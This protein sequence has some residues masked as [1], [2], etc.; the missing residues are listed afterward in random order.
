MILARNHSQE[1]PVLPFS[2]V[3]SGLCEAYRNYFEEF[4]GA[5]PWGLCCSLLGWEGGT[6][7]GAQR[8]RAVPRAALVPWYTITCKIY[9]PCPLPNCLFQQAFHNTKA[10]E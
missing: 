5:G 1:G 6:D 2:E 8:A 7:R 9:L 3:S 4:R 10:K